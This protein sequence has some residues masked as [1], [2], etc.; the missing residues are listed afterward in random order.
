MWH[1]RSE[2]APSPRTRT[3]V[4]TTPATVSSCI[5][6]PV[7]RFSSS[8][9]AAKPTAATATNTAP[10]QGS[11]S[12][13]TEGRE[14]E[15]RGRGGVG[16]GWWKGRDSTRL[17]PDTQ[18]LERWTLPVATDLSV[19][20]VVMGNMSA[21]ST[22]PPHTGAHARWSVGLWATS[23]AA[24]ARHTGAAV[25]SSCDKCR[26]PRRH[27]LQPPSCPIGLLKIQP[28]VCVQSQP[29]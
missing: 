13:P 19:R 28:C 18:Q 20:S 27:F 4:M 7:M 8:W 14:P 3:R 10:S 12:T 9:M 5:W 1:C 24:A 2:P 29:K 21:A 23:T 17:P 11:S 16:G 6:T 25:T 22:H 15:W 26:R